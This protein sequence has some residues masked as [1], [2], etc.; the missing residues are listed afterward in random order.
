[1]TREFIVLLVLWASLLGVIPKEDRNLDELLAEAE[2]A[3]QSENYQTAVEAFQEVIREAPHNV[4]ALHGLA[5]LYA[6]A[7]DP[8]FN[9]GT[10]A[11]EW[12]LMALD[13]SPDNPGIIETLALGYF[14]QN[15]FERAIHECMRCIDL[16]EYEL[17]YY[18]LLKKFA[19]TWMARL[20]INHPSREMEEKHRAA[21]FLGRAQYHLGEAEEG[22]TELE[23]AYKPDGT[24]PPEVCLYLARAYRVR[25]TPEEAVEVLLGL[26]ES[27]NRDPLLLT[28][29][30]RAQRASGNLE[31]ASRYYQEA[32]QLNPDHPGVRA[33]LGEIYLESEK[34]VKAVLILKEAL[35]NLDRGTLTVHATE[36]R[37][38]HLLGRA[39]GGAGETEEGILRIL[40]A[41][42][43]DPGLE[44]AARDLEM[45]YARKT[46]S[47]KGFRE[48]LA[49]RLPVD[50]VFFVEGTG[51]AGL[52]HTG[53]PAF[54][55]YDG[56]GDPD[57]FLAGT[58]LYEND[59][60]GRFEDVTDKKNLQGARGDGGLF[61][62]FDNDG[63]L[64]LYVVVQTS[65]MREKLYW[66]EGKRGFNEAGDGAGVYGDLYP[67][68][69][70]CLGDFDG[71]GYLDVFLANGVG[72]EASNSKGYPDSLIMS[73]G[74]GVFKDATKASGI[75]GLP[76]LCAHGASLAD[77]DN[78]GD[79]DIFVANTA[80]GA[81]RLF[82]NSGRTEGRFM[83]E[84]LSLGMAGENREDRYGNTAG[85]AFGD[86][87][88]DGD[89]DL[90]VSNRSALRHFLFADRSQL[91]FNTGRP[92]FGFRSKPDRSGIHYGPGHHQ[93]AFGDVNNDGR[94]DL[95]LTSNVPEECA[96]LYLGRDD[97]SFL[98]VTWL[99]GIQ[100]KN[101]WG[102][103]I[104][105][106]DLD[107]DLDLLIGGKEQPHLFIN[108]GNNNHWLGLRLAG[109]HCNGTAIGARVT[110]DYGGMSQIREVSG[111]RGRACQ[112]DMVVHFGLGSYSGRMSVS[113]R[114]PD[115]RNDFITG[116]KPDR[117]HNLKQ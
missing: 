111:G 36:A 55:D 74:K 88:S 79:L 90:F 116:L 107:G 80:L 96:R 15:K 113:L 109:K 91:L 78:D 82:R 89:L 77:F 51:D 93:C 11:V 70:A 106:V 32:Y 26:G 71:D 31:A 66:N 63:D 52:A 13:D 23:R 49:E 110:L 59:G 28:E 117:I 10:L 29:L 108:Q 3:V 97:G 22:A 76:P 72:A 48:Y 101:T 7:S 50:V 1:M 58:W 69:S 115:G 57:L 54:G 18:R 103:A 9:D 42:N 38:L 21:Y 17:H 47:L 45:L 14:A 114:W 19:R 99:A 6:T 61:G 105:D 8:D 64:D 2:A 94:M 30:G 46:G 4:R 112:D 75:D 87:D 40:H 102:C 92:N 27:L 39:L 104:A 100:V 62:D 83:E 20:N 84:A 73:S 86:V 34:H 60:R 33:D 67:T 16:N 68:R 95:F 56:D 53:S 5:R 85:C 44:G 24:S 65:G 37:I 25:G 35:D 43:L 81:N 98:D 41:L 12:A